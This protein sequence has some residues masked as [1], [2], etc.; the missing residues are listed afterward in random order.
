[1]QDEDHLV[2]GLRDQVLLEGQLHPVCQRLQEAERSVDV[3]ADP[4]LHPRD[5]AAFEP[6]V[7]QR[8]HHEDDEDEEPLDGDAPPHV[9]AEDLE[10]VVHDAPPV[11]VTSVPGDARSARTPLP[12]ELDG[13]QTAP[14]T[15]SSATA[16]A[17]VIEPRSPV[18][19]TTEPW[20]AWSAGLTSATGVR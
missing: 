12:T 9:V 1:R 6:D 8:Q 13:T 4:M 10:P 2:G 19:V 16:A 11:I 20:A 17:S 3:G 5:D 7:E 14:S 18:R 15:R